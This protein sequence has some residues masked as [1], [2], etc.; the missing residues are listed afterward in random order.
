MFRV[1]PEGTIWFPEFLILA[2]TVMVE[3]SSQEVEGEIKESS[4]RSCVFR[5][6]RTVSWLVHWFTSLMRT[7]YIP[8]PG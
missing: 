5:V 7:W 2:D 8:R 6:T 3:E 1:S 4:S